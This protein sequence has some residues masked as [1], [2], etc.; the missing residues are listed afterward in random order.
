MS[1][2][3]ST[4]FESSQMDSNSTSTPNSK[5]KKDTFRHFLSKS[6]RLFHENKKKDK[7]LVISA[8]KLVYDSQVERLRSESLGSESSSSFSSGLASEP[9]GE[10]PLPSTLQIKTAPRRYYSTDSITSKSM[11]KVENGLK[12]NQNLL[13]SGQNQIATKISELN[14][15]ENQKKYEYQTEKQEDS[16]DQT[17]GIPS[18]KQENQDESHHSDR[19]PSASPNVQ[20]HLPSTSPNVQQRLPSESSSMPT[21]LQNKNGPPLPSSPAPNTSFRK[22]RSTLAGEEMIGSNLVKI[23][24]QPPPLPPKLPPVRK[25]KS[26]PDI[27]RQ[28]PLRPT[29]KK[30]GKEEA[31]SSNE[32][33]PKSVAN[34]K[35][36]KEQPKSVANEKETKEESKYVAKEASVSNVSVTPPNYD[37]LLENVEMYDKACRK[38]QKCYR[39]WRAIKR[40]VL[41]YRERRKNYRKRTGIVQ[42]I[43]TTE[44]NYIASLKAC[45]QVRKP[46][47]ITQR[48]SPTFIC[49]GNHYTIAESETD[50]ASRSL[51]DF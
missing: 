42:E 43:L 20:Q 18:K 19:P 22:R 23:P 14:V 29:Q 7:D 40:D 30:E 5:G 25:M 41:A 39:K 26:S 47:Q 6:K 27:S 10:L 24:S 45:V 13:K 48:N 51:L 33:E 1:S 46:N 11:S 36:T 50:I 38:I 49:L 32:Q 3:N 28:I 12:S 16:H 37:Y 8:P 4:G 31:K 44:K 2:S 15:D 34:E 17:L 35:E 9:S 21:S